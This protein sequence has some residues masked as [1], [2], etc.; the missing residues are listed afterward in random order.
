VSI[1]VCCNS[2]AIVCGRWCS[3]NHEGIGGVRSLGCGCRYLGVSS[4]TSPCPMYLGGH[5]GIGYGTWSCK[6]LGLD[7]R[8]SDGGT[9]VLVVSIMELRPSVER[10]EPRSR[11]VQL[12]PGQ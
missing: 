1:I 10:V 9:V 5:R 12:V 8:G 3:I 6:Y 11:S 7:P 4:R 2:G